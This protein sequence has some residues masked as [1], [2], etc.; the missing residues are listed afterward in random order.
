MKFPAKITN[1]FGVEEHLYLSNDILNYFQVTIHPAINIEHRESESDGTSDCRY[2][3][4]GECML[5]QFDLRL[6]PFRDPN[7]CRC[8][9]KTR[10]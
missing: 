8:I 3:I 5:F 7:P 1:R 6:P 2:A 9:E 4:E 10:R